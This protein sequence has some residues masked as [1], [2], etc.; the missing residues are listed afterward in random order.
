VKE[1]IKKGDVAVLDEPKAEAPSAEKAEKSEEK[2]H[3]PQPQGK[4]GKAK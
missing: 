1:L 2:A 3:A 4:S